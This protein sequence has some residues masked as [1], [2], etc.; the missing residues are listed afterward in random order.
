MSIFIAVPRYLDSYCFLVSF[1]A[2]SVRQDRL[3]R[4]I[5]LSI[6]IERA[7]LRH[8]NEE[9]KTKKPEQLAPSH[10]LLGVKLQEQ[11][12]L[13]GLSALAFLFEMLTSCKAP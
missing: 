6:N 10:F 1:Y 5:T 7:R 13:Q 9:V 4:K 12:D 8:W 11:R 3:D 2:Y